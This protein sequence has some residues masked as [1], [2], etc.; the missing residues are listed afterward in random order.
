MVSLKLRKNSKIFDAPCRAYIYIYQ[1]LPC[2][3]NFAP[4]KVIETR[5]LENSLKGTLKNL[6]K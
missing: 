3:Q 5:E 6:A 4:R 1:L 2:Y